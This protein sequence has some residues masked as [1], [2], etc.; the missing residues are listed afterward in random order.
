[1]KPRTSPRSPLPLTVLLGD[2][3]PV[4]CSDVGPGGLCLRLARVFVPGAKVHGSV[5]RGAERYPFS[6]EV[7]WADPGDFRALS[8][9]RVGIR[10]LQAPQG[11]SGQL[12]ATRPERPSRPGR[13]MAVVRRRT[14]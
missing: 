3:I 12:G 6:G 8:L 4:Q 13:R 11:L 5:V 2:R 7:A 10:F 14:A 1:M 9:S